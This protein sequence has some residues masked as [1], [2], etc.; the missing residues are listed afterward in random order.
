MATLPNERTIA[1]QLT[2]EIEPML[3]VSHYR[4]I[5]SHL[6][7]RAFPKRAVPFWLFAPAYIT[8]TRVHHANVTFL[9][10]G[11]QAGNGA[12]RVGALLTLYP[13]VGGVNGSGARPGAD[14]S[15]FIR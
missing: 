9:S 5:R 14:R 13:F 1:T 7:S 10:P 6:G 4:I 15:A 11:R 12:L 2:S 3:R 8:Q